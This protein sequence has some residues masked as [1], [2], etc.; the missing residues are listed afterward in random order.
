M[1]LVIYVNFFFFLVTYN[2]YLFETM[3]WH[4]LLT[5]VA[6]WTV[7]VDY[8]LLKSGLLITVNMKFISDRVDFN[9]KQRD[10][11]KWNIKSWLK[12]VY[13]RAYINQTITCWKQDTFEPIRT[14]MKGFPF[15]FH[16][17]ILNREHYS[18]THLPVIKHWVHM[19]L[20][21]KCTGENKNFKTVI[22]GL[23]FPPCEP[24]V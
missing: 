13:A 12:G 10:W 1:V 9:V 14:I 21:K 8:M 24:R 18:T 5:K 20:K 4:W 23:F 19:R 3:N 22:F 6:E 2:N 15:L 7:A 16:E 17:N 11:G